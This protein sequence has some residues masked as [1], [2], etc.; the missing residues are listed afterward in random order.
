MSRADLVFS[1]ASNRGLLRRY[2]PKQSEMG[3]GL[4]AQMGFSRAAL[5]SSG[6]FVFRRG[7]SLGLERE[8]SA[9]QHISGVLNKSRLLF[10]PG[11]ISVWINF[12]ARD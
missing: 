10:F 8:F 11:T 2:S 4:V 1:K 9:A 5:S 3:G 12:V 7:V 6:H